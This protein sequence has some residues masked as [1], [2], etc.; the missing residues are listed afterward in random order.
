MEIGLKLCCIAD[1]TV[2][3]TKLKGI[4][5][6]VI[7]TVPKNFP[8]SFPLKWFFRGL[9]GKVMDEFWLQAI[10]LGNGSSKEVVLIG[11][12]FLK[13]QLDLALILCTI[14]YGVIH[15]ISSLPLLVV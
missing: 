2:I 15:A 12:H 11:M 8:T 6:L 3:T 5:L 1:T 7:I 14:L 4:M 13:L 9:V 10:K